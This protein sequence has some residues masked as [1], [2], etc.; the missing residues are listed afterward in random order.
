M[1]KFFFLA[2]IL[3]AIGYTVGWY[4]LANNLQQNLKARLIELKSQGYRVEYKD[5]KVEGF[6]FSISVILKDPLF[7]QSDIFKTWVEGDLQFKT[8]VWMPQKVKA[9]AQ[10]IC[11]FDFQL[12]T[13]DTFNFISQGFTLNLSPFFYPSDYEMTFDQTK[14]INNTTS[15]AHI[16][17][18]ALEIRRSKPE[19]NELP[20]AKLCEL[21]V[22]MKD[23]SGPILEGNPFSPTLENIELHT[24]LRGTSEGT[25]IAN[26]LNSWYQADGTF[27]VSR[28]TLNWG[29]LHLN[30]EG[31]L[32]LDEHLQP[33][34]AFSTEIKGLDKALDALVK[35]Q[36]VKKKNAQLAKMALHFLADAPQDPTLA[37]T[38]RASISI[39][40]SKVDL[41]PVT[42]FKIPNINWNNKEKVFK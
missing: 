9:V 1:R 33:L 34:A 3:G 5:I 20:P 17:K 13:T 36:I 16:K 39:Q 10:S 14:I 2:F 19:V 30:A 32:S 15:L 24:V 6:P 29:P 40:D 35:G 7:S 4:Y 8:A 26:K 38:H 27:E 12:N 23:I 37:G 41:G 18:V 42:L 25:T 28:L 31:T 22:E 11:H 21:V